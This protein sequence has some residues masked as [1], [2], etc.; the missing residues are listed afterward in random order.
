IMNALIGAAADPEA[1]VRITAVRA[2]GLIS[3][4][5]I[6]PVLAAHLTDEARLVR[7]SAAE[8]LTAHGVVQL[9][10]PPGEALTRALDEWADSL[11]TF[12]DVSADHTTLGWLEATRGRR[13]EAEKELKTAIALDP[14]DARPH[15]YLG[16]LAAREGHFEE[17]VKHFKAAKVITPGYRNLD[18]LL[19]EASGRGTKKH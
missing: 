11:R 1:M 19:D 8:A 4:P 18:R 16:V 5:R 15:V 6:P 17:A 10:G 2:L 13:E 9:A 7:V 14:A 12:N 3:D